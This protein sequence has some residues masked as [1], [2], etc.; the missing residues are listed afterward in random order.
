MTPCPDSLE[1]FMACMLL[2]LNGEALGKKRVILQF[3]FSG[4]VEASCYFTLERGNIESTTGTSHNYTIAIETPFELWMNIITGMVNGR[5]MFM[6]HKYQVEGDLAL[7]QQIFQ[8][9]DDEYN[10]LI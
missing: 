3:T 10:V 4:E 1:T 6:Q 9:K 2:R 5:E 8:N 7:M